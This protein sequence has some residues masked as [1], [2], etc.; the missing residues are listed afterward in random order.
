[1]RTRHPCFGTRLLW[2]LPLPTAGLRYR[3]LALPS[4]YWTGTWDGHPHLVKS[5]AQQ[6]PSYT[7]TPHRF[8]S[9][10]LPGAGP[11]RGTVIPIL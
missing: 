2:V 4:G 7:R 6:T 9:P 10:C 8:R 1:M 11:V 3:A 5:A